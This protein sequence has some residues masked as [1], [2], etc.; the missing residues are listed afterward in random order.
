MIWRCKVLL[1]LK[2]LLLAARG[3]NRW[4][5]PEKICFPNVNIW[6]Q[7]TSNEQILPTSSF[8]G[9]ARWWTTKGRRVKTSLHPH[10]REGTKPWDTVL[11]SLA[12]FWL[13]CF[14]RCHSVWAFTNQEVTPL[15]LAGMVYSISVSN[16]AMNL[17][18]I[19]WDVGSH[20]ILIAKMRGVKVE[21]KS[22]V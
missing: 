2:I 3:Q 19:S 6:E 20:S 5:R 9:A 15:D 17:K 14:N 10:L 12:V 8:T 18:S 21:E 16:P 13:F 1:L 7:K 4:L 11:F 22:P